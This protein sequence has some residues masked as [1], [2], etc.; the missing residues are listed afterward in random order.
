MVKLY[1]HHYHER[2]S[3]TTTLL[4]G[5]A[6]LGATLLLQLMF[7]GFMTSIMSGLS[8]GSVKAL[9]ETW[10]A[11]REKRIKARQEARQVGK[12]GGLFGRRRR[13]SPETAHRD[14][15]KSSP[16]G[17]V[18]PPLA[19]KFDHDKPRSILGPDTQEPDES[20][21]GQIEAA[22]SVYHSNG[23][24]WRGARRQRHHDRRR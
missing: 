16:E 7:P 23:R 11:N 17:D 12:G 18:E 3:M 10:S 19:P 14:A 24:T 2:D 9:L 1:L 15:A 5:A 13:R 4:I 21:H 6:A 8:Y 20:R 22:P